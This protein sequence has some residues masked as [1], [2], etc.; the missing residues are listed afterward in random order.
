MAN[1]TSETPE[2]T[3]VDVR[4]LP[5]VHPPDPAEL[6][7]ERRWLREVAGRPWLARARAY[8]GRGGPGYLQSALTL[9]GGS[10]SASLL[11]GAAFGYDLL[12]VAPLGMLMGGVVLAA[13]AHQTLSTGERPFEA[14][15]RHAGGVFAWGWAIGALMA[16]VV[17]HFA[18]YS[19]AS[20]VVVD[21]GAAAG[22]ELP[23]FGAG[24]AILL[25]AVITA[26]TF[27]SGGAANR[28]F[29]RVLRWMVWMIVALFGVVAVRAG[30]DDPGAILRGFTSFRLP[31]DRGDV[32]AIALVISGLAAAVGVNM[33]F[34]YPYT[35]LARGWGREHRE[36]ARFDLGLG[37]V[38]PY[39]IATAL[40]TITAANTVHAD[41]SGT[42]ISPVEAA[43]T[44][45]G[46]LGP[47]WGRVLFDL[48]LL[49]MLLTTITLHMVCAGFA[50]SEMFG[51]KFGSRG[52]RLALLLP[53]PGVLGSLFWS[54]LSVWLAVPT[55]VI[56]GFLLPLAYLGFVK[57]QRSTAYLGDDR[58]R[59]ASGAAW[60]GGM[61]LATVVLLVFLGWYLVTK[62][63][64]FLERITG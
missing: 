64:G 7:Q 6:E 29:E 13:V 4:G 1:P 36:L 19:L 63:P 53:T 25:W 45:G 12:W 44:L 9:G 16:S 31:E 23:R 28:I 32:A 46:L 27:G 38:V 3:G 26:Q 22:A 33:L 41:F 17:W 14:M 35:L 10:A 24:L 34:L 57:L 20:A 61:V 18:Q 49:S 21:L 43:Q 47:V 8:V 59:G 51:L 37:M 52:Y 2:P 60:I 40:M 30:I 15:R 50:C 62:G 48:G 5:M 42:S 55:G 56:T 39:A 54:D 58:P 11:A